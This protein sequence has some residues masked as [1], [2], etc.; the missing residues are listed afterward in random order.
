LE[1]HGVLLVRL[2]RDL[3]KK[4]ALVRPLANYIHELDSARREVSRDW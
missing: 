4:L 1:R 3:S 2:H